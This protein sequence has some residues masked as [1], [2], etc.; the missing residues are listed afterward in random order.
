MTSAQDTA[1]HKLE[2][3]SLQQMLG[4]PTREHVNKMRGAIATVYAKAKTSHN[5]SPLGSKVG[6]SAAILK[7]DKNISLHNTVSTGITST[8]NLANT[9]PFTHPSRPD[10][11]Y[12]T[13]LAIHPDIYRRK[14]EA[15][16]AELITQYDIFKGYEEAFKDKIFLA[17]D[18]E[19]LATIKNEI[20]RFAKKTVAQML[21]HIEQQCLALTAQD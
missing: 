6:F 21:D 7:K 9:W 19:Y 15:Q 5:S 14:K 12:D 17:C 8:A 18:K 1:V 2:G 3:K 10:T 4:R 20:F 13:I 11:Y 16:P